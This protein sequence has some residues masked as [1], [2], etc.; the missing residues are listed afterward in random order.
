MRTGE[1]ALVGIRGG[2]L[3][4]HLHV[5]LGHALGAVLVVNTAEVQ[6]VEAHSGGQP[7]VRV[8]VAKG[9]DLPAHAGEV[10]QLLLQELVTFFIIFLKR[11]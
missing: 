7:G 3:P 1:H 11:E 10:V 5:L 9:V 8:R 2:A 6:R 4:H